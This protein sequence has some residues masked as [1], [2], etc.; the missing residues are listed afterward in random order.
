[1]Q[2]KAKILFF[3]IETSPNLAYVWA[4]YQQDVI[5]YEREWQLLSFAWKWQGDSKVRVLSQRHNSEDQLVRALHRLFQQADIL[6]AHN[7]DEFD[8][9]KARAKFLE[10]GLPPPPRT[11]SVDTKK[12]AKQNFMLNSNSLNDIGKLLKIG[13]KVETGGFGLWLG[14]M[15]GKLK[16][17]QKMEKY[18]KQDVILL[19]KVYDKLMPWVKNHPSVGLLSGGPKHSCPNCGSESLKKKGLRANTKTLQQQWQCKDC[20]SWHL[21]PIRKVK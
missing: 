17:W 18:N 11:P 6:V 21:T 5:A 19:E 7:G 20:H 12:V 13:Q 16:S 15:S 1:M 8:I 2:Q 14:C 4:K 10:H 9:K 3:D